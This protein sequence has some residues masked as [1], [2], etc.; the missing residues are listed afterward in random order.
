MGRALLSTRIVRSGRQP[1]L[2]A[3]SVRQWRSWWGPSLSPLVAIVWAAATAVSQGR[4]VV[5]R[6]SPP[7]DVFAHGYSVIATRAPSTW[8]SPKR[9]PPPMSAPHACSPC[10]PRIQPVLMMSPPIE[11]V[12]GASSSTVI[13]RARNPDQEPASR[14]QDL[15]S[16]RAQSSRSSKAHWGGEKPAAKSRIA[17]SVEAAQANGAK[18]PSPP[19]VP[20]RCS[21]PSCRACHQVPRTATMPVPGGVVQR[22]RANRVPETVCAP[23]RVKLFR[24]AASKGSAFGGV[25]QKES[26]RNLEPPVVSAQAASAPRCQPHWAT[27]YLP[28]LASAATS[29]S[30]ARPSN[31]P[32]ATRRPRPLRAPDIVTPSLDGNGRL[33]ARRRPPLPPARMGPCRPRTR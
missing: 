25:A 12:G 26:G 16:A 17:R 19:S 29:K 7:I 23:S 1:T 33:R 13:V 22:Q 14:L 6:H 4:M 8:V 2:P 3:K 9:T 30:S 32:N 24:W 10:G 5:A 11:P 15:L 31:T 18:P 21:N 27:A 28:A 20:S